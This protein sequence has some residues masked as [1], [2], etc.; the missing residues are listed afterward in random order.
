[1]LKAMFPLI[2]ANDPYRDIVFDGG[3]I[4]IE[5]DPF[6]QAIY[7]T[8]SELG[9]LAGLADNPGA[10]QSLLLAVVQHQASVFSFMLDL[11]LNV[12]SGGDR[13]YEGSYWQERAPVYDLRQVAKDGIPTYLV[14]G[15]HHLFQRG[16]PLN[17][18]GLQNA[19][20]GRSVFA[21][22]A[23]RQRVSGRYQLTIGPWYHVTADQGVDMSLVELDWFDRWLKGERTG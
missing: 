10:L 11:L 15:L 18:A 21:P 12:G 13:A 2:A 4:D 20:D 3:I 5:F 19:A 1:P 8:S 9:P 7:E 14:G 6:I 17:Y 16:E 22:M 23:P